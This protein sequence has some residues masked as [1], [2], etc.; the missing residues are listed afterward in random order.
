MRETCTILG[1]SIISLQTIKG[2]F[3]DVAAYESMHDQNMEA[4]ASV[5]KADPP[6][7]EALVFLAP[8]YG[9][10]SW[11]GGEKKHAVLRVVFRF[12]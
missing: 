7:V 8:P 4:P 11:R 3:A 1:Y 9:Q 12:L 6:G 5:V 10:R 2:C